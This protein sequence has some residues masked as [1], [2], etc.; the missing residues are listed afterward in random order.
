MDFHTWEPVYERI[1]ADFG[2]DRAGDEQAR[3]ILEDLLGDSPVYEPPAGAF[4]GET[5]AI[6]GGGP[7]LADHLDLVREADSVVAASLAAERVVDHG[8]SVDLMVT[9]LDKT[10]AFATDLTHE[11]TPV[12]VHAHGDNI[13][14]LRKH[15]PGFETAAVL[16]TT[17]AAPTATV[18]NY[19]GFTDGDRAAFLA[20]ALGAEGLTFPGWSFDDPTVGPEK[21][22]KLQWAK[23]LLLWL[24]RRR[25]ER[26]DVL[27]GVRDEVDDSILPVED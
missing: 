17:Q 15:V 9:D 27:D 1:L 24:E 12:A 10:P 4:E 3:D 20:D 5:V 13:P 18:S 26:F 14:A 6:V 19:G 11:G 16:P 25:G 22:R 8:L 7:N 21:A 2:Y 23:R